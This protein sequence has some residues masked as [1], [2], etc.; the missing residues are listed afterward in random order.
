M[1]M[2]VLIVLHSIPESS[3]G[4]MII[5]PLLLVPRMAGIVAFHCS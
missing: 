5:Q 1:K 4:S 3:S 2:E